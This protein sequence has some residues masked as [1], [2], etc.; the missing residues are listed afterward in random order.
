MI[1][2][3]VKI[4]RIVLGITGTNGAGKGTIV[5]FLVKKKAFEHFSASGLITEEIIKRKMPVN[6][7]MMIMVANDLR[8]KFGA[9]YIAE[10]LLKR[11]E[12]SENN[13]IIESIRTLGEVKKLKEVGGLLVA[14]DANQKLRYKRILLRGGSKDG[15]SF[16][17][18][19]DQ[20]KREKESD[21]PNKQNLLACKK[22]A[23]YLIENNG[24]IE[25]L[26][27][28]IEKLLIRI[29]NNE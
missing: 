11:A 26:D 17:E 29:K 3:S 2:L 16:K 21:D 20:E 1:Y 4:D 10:E 22:A 15:V 25:E 18:F 27:E 13:V 24:S 8:T 5:D 6:R 9:G 19:M 28:K 23:D 14:V 7:E 12:K